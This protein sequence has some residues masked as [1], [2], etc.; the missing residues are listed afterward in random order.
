LIAD[1]NSQRYHARTKLVKK[2]ALMSA[3]RSC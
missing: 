1:K 2:L 3:N